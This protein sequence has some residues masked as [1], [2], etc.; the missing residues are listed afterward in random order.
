MFRRKQM[1]IQINNPSLVHCLSLSQRD[2]SCFSRSLATLAEV[3]FWTLCV[4][5]VV[6]VSDGWRWIISAGPLS[7]SCGI[8]LLTLC[9]HPA[10]ASPSSD[11]QT[12]SRPR[13]A[14]RKDIYMRLTPVLKMWGQCVL[15]K[16]IQNPMICKFY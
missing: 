6:L 10:T 8:V 14:H 7:A 5:F 13:A 3:Y 2:A 11:P 1:L 9:Y 15:C 16:T 4:F 12:Q